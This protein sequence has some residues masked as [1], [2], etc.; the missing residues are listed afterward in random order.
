MLGITG[1]NLPH[2]WINTVNKSKTASA[3]VIQ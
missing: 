2:S 3:I 1:Q